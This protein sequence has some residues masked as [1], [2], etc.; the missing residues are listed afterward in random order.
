MMVLGK[1]SEILARGAGT[2]SFVTWDITKND[3]GQNYLKF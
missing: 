2:S 3:L 1:I